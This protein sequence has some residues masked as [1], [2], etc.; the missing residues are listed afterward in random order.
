MSPARPHGCD[1]PAVAQRP[2]GVDPTQHRQGQGQRSPGHVVHPSRVGRAV[3]GPHLGRVAGSA[4]CRTSPIPPPAAG[5][6]RTRV[7]RA[8]TARR[9]P[10]WRPRWR[11]TPPIRARHLEVFLALAALAPAG[12]RGRGARR[13]RGRRRRGLTHDKTSD[14]AT[15]LLTGRDGRQALLALH[16][17]RHAGRAGGPTPARCRSR[18]RWRP[19]RRCRRARRRCV[20]DVAGPTTYAVE[21]GLLEG[22][23]RGWTLARH[24]ARRA[25]PGSGARRRTQDQLRNRH[26]TAP[27]YPCHRPTGRDLSSTRRARSDK[28]RLTPTRTDRCTTRS[29]G[30]VRTD[31]CDACRRTLGAPRASA[32]RAGALVVSE[33]PPAAVT[34]PFDP[35]RTHQHRATHQRPDP[36]T[37]GPARRTQRRDRRHRP[38][39]RGPQARPGS[40]PRPRR[41][42]PDGQ[43]PGL[44][45][46][47]LREVQVRERPEGP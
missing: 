5:R 32:R 20:V 39:G 42:R 41:D 29:S 16:R 13:G 28:W 11:R 44:Q 24:R 30:P 27:L 33:G 37:R 2:P 7:S 43:A 12:A 36:G 34:Q 17:P 1:H 21:G 26:P 8:T 4:P 47:G 9:T 23:A 15:A 10:T 46:H 35:W 38:H 14:M 3:E 45:A 6:S 31:R 40:R 22:L 18:R 19:G 25:R